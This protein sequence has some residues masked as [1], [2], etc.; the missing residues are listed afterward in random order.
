MQPAAHTVTAAP[1]LRTLLP[2]APLSA[3][4]AALEDDGAVIVHRLLDAATV[5]ALQHELAPALAVTAPGSR[6][7]DP[8]WELFHGAHT[9]R[10]TGLVNWS[11]TFV[12]LVQHPLLTAWADEVLGPLCGSYSLNG[13]EL[14]AIGPGEDQQYLHRDQS[15]WPWF[16][17]L[18]PE[19]P[20]VTIN[21]IV[22]LTPFTAENG[23]THVVPGSHRMTED[24]AYAPDLAVPAE[25]A[26]GSVLLFS[27]KTV[28]GAGA[29]RT[30]AARLGLHVSYVL[31]WLRTAENHQ[32]AVPDEVVRRLPQPVRKLLNFEQY[33]PAPTGGGRLGL[34]D[35]EDPALRY[36][37]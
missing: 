5:A 23:A 8:E 7:G 3:V 12:D 35:L 28:H 2:T 17:T 36:A 26:P 22:A 30:G 20:E 31:G 13:G 34:V 6:S 15:A 21:A 9:R 18:G 16:N 25:M 4:L 29:N 1:A 33:D 37:A 27:G 11:P 14:M 19:G 24:D 32:L 10:A